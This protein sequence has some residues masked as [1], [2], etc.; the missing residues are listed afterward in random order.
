MKMLANT[1]PSGDALEI[2]RRHQFCYSNDD[3]K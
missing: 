3:Q 2:W 1:G